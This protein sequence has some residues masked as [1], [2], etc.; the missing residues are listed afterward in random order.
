MKISDMDAYVRK[1][2]QEPDSSTDDFLPTAE[3]LLYLQEGHIDVAEKARCLRKS[4]PLNFTANVANASLPN[5]WV[6]TLRVY[7]DHPLL[8]TSMDKLD[9]E[10]QGYDWQAD[11]GDPMYFYHFGRELYTWPVKASAYTATLYYAWIPEPTEMEAGDES[12]LPREFQFCVIRYAVWQVKMKQN[13]PAD[14]DTLA[15]LQQYESSVAQKMAHYNENQNEFNR[16]A[17]LGAWDY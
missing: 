11:R 13:G 15:A 6:D 10:R 4:T 2:V 3:L 12:P 8:E 17:T 5:D 7:T 1:L 9:I 14:S 16:V